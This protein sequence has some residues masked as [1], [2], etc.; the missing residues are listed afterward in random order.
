MVYIQAYK[1]QENYFTQDTV[2]F[3]NQIL[4]GMAKL[5]AIILQE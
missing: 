2:A 3:C 5:E 4:I 1:S